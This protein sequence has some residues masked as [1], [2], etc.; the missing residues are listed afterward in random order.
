MENLPS[1]RNILQFNTT[2]CGQFE[3]TRS[4]FGVLGPI[5]IP[6]EEEITPRVRGNNGRFRN[7]HDEKH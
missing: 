1:I 3:G 5:G 6:A 4:K 2:N 7:L